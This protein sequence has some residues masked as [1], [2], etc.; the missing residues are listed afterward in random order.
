MKILVDERDIEEL[1]YGMRVGVGKEAACYL[2]EDDNKI[3]KIYKDGYTVSN[4][5]ENEIIHKQ[6]AYPIDTLY[7]SKDVLRGYT[8]NYLSGEHFIHGFSQNLT[9]KDL[10]KA[11]LETRMILLKLQDVY[12]DDNC[13]DNMIYDYRRNRINLIDTSRWYLKHDGHLES[14]NEF[15]WQMMSAILEN[16]DWKHFKLNKDKVLFELH[17]TYKYLENI[18]SLFL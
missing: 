16:I 6:I 3:V 5:L 8:M 7:D 13:L 2:P 10:K 12:M 11:Y 17:M 9:L 14:I 1:K 18:P 4:L 15:N